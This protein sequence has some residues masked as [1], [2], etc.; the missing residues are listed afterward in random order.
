MNA[1][2]LTEVILPL[3]E[4]TTYLADDVKLLHVLIKDLAEK[5]ESVKIELAKSHE[6]LS[7]H[8]FNFENSNTSTKSKRR[9]SSR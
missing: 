6:R 1:G 3:K 7:S 5:M 9:R 2:A 8:L 4:Q